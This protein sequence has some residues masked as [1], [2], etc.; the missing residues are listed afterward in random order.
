MLPLGSRP[1]RPSRAP[2]AAA[3]TALAIALA[4]AIVIAPSPAGAAPR[5]SSLGWVRGA[6]AETCAGTRALAEA[7]EARLGRQVF[8]SA[9]RADVAVEGLIERSPTGAWRAT[10]TLAGESGRVLGA[11]EIVRE[12]ASCRDLDAPLALVIAVMID[13][14]AALREP[15]APAL[16]APLPL[17]PAP[18]PPA[19]PPREIVPVPPPAPPPRKPWLAG[20]HIGPVLSLGMLPGFG[21]GVALRSRITP[22]GFPAFEIG[23]ALWAPSQSEAGG[24][25]ARFS[26]A[27]GVL[28]VCP[29]ATSAL[30]FELGACAGA[31]VGAIHAGGFGFALTEERER[32]TV[33]GALEGRVRRRIIGPLALAIGPGLAIPFVRDRFF[34]SGPTG[35]K[36]EVFRMSPLAGTLEITLGAEFP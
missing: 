28:S 15:P 6:G 30:G 11:R 24:I 18:L 10:I 25:G 35:E 14:D 5:S 16:P 31:R 34:Y 32:P 9:A 7:V 19:P 27:E 33:I 2:S 12:A 29:L 4:L 26:L 22:P 8:V 20:V 13:P 36:L 23:G 17:P 3:A 21:A 1:R